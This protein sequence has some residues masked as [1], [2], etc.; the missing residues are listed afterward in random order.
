MDSALS[1]SGFDLHCRKAELVL[2]YMVM[3]WFH[4]RGFDSLAYSF[5]RVTGLGVVAF[6]QLVPN[7]H[8]GP[9]TSQ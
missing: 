2:W 5:I 3:G 4:W 9:F 7:I 8:I 1:F 6:V